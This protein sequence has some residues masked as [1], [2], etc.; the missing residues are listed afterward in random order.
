VPRPVAIILV[1]CAAAAASLTLG[2]ALA[3]GPPRPAPPD[4][5]HPAHLTAAAAPLAGLNATFRRLAPE[6]RCDAADP[7]AATARRL[8]A[9]ANKN[10]AKAPPKVLRRK[11]ASLR[12]AIRL[13]RDAGELCD[14][15]VAPGGAPA[16]PGTTAPAPGA[17]QVPP[18]PPPP[19][20]GSQALSFTGRNFSFDPSTP[21]TA[22][23]GIALRLAMTNAAS[24]TSHRIGVRTLPAEVLLGQSP[25]VDGGQSTFVDLTLIAGSYE[26]FCGVGD[27]AEAGMVVPLTVTP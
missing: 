7:K 8:R 6:A 11:K 21:Q 22:R 4:A 18:A 26:I 27:H 10:A 1:L 14:G 12:R 24:A 13:L 25:V 17:G 19:Q 20:P 16:A 2:S 15:P 9:A 5:A 23:A 3:S